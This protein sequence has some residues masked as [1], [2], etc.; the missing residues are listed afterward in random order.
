MSVLRYL[1]QLKDNGVWNAFCESKAL[2]KQKVSY[3]AV[4]YTLR[5]VQKLE[6]VKYIIV[7]DLFIVNLL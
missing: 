2:P 3:C 7:I 5:R 4:I 1:L 6:I